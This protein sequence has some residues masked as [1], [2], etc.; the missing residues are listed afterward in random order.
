MTQGL[1]INETM[2]EWVRCPASHQSLR[3]ATPDELARIN[4]FLG[5]SQLATVGGDAIAEPLEGA[6]IR[7]DG[8]ILYPVV[9]G[10][11]RLIV[12]D[13]IQVPAGLSFPESSA[14]LDSS[15]AGGADEDD[16]SSSAAGD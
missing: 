14:P 4:V 2:L 16:L 9:D 1:R 12:D 6:L 15:A 7:E 11:A 10:I 13:G 5:E 8:K 3:I